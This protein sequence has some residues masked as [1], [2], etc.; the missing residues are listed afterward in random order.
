ML[1]CSVHAPGISQVAD[2]LH[3]PCGEATAENGRDG[4]GVEALDGKLRKG[5]VEGEQ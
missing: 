2:R 1:L 4:R 5:G 3:V